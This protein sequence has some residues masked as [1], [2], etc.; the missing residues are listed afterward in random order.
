VSAAARLCIVSA[1][2]EADLTWIVGLEQEAFADPWSVSSLRAELHEPSSLVLLATAEGARVGFAAFR[3]LPPEAE[4]LRIAVAPSWRRRGIAAELLQ[5]GLVRL[6]SRGVEQTFLEV[7]ISNTAAIALYGS[8]GFEHIATRP[9][10]YNDGE[11]ALLFR[12]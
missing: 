4:I 12:R 3:C 2:S 11:D 7:R 1:A 9:G 8:L 10:Y 5:I 6:R